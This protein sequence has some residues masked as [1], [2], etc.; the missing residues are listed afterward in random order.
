MKNI[1][2]LLFVSLTFLS[3]ST[4]LLAEDVVNTP[5]TELIHE[6]VQLEAESQRSLASFFSSLA[7]Q[8]GLFCNAVEAQSES[9]PEIVDTLQA[10]IAENTNIPISTQDALISD[11]EE[12]GEIL[13]DGQ[14]TGPEIAHFITHILVTHN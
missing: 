14:I 3:L 5:A 6:T 1:Q 4:G 11:L 12:I 2:T 10:T 9:H 7:E 8:I 13:A